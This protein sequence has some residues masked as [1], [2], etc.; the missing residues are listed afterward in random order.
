MKRSYYLLGL[1]PCVLLYWSCSSSPSSSSTT[2]TSSTS[3]TG[4]TGGG[5]GAGGGS[6]FVCPESGVTKGP[7]AL[8]AD[9]TSVKIRWEACRKGSAPEVR[10]T[11]EAGGAETVAN[12]VET[13]F[14][15]TET[16]VAP[17]IADT[18][19]DAAGTYYMHEAKLQNLSPGTCYTYSLAAEPAR[20]GRFCTMRQPGEA[21]RFMAIGDTNPGLGD[22]AENVL[23]HALP[24]NPD[25]I[26][27]G[28]DIQYYDSG[29]ETWA[30]WFPAMQPMLSQGAMYT[31][32]GN[33]ESEKPDEYEQYTV[34]FFGDASVKTAY[35]R[36]SSGGVW[37]FA[38]D[39]E[40]SLDVGS[41]Q[42]T[43]FES[44]LKDASQQPGY[45]FSVVFFHKPWVTCGDTGDNPTARAAFE[46]LL[47]QYGVKLVLQAHMHGYERFELGDLTYVTAAGG[48]GKIGDVNDNDTRDYCVNR[49]K[50][51]PFRHA[52][53]VDIKQGELMGTVI[54]DQGKVQDT[55]TKVVP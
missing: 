53:I 21:L 20:K 36:F 18:P 14:V 52:L 11:P 3:S 2:G 19:P 28:G 49:V 48:G 45:R 10:F 25:F 55:F 32:I 42:A 26:L 29:L 34:R 15:V 7:W 39:T 23:A 47:L 9:T 35:Y 41:D 33:H 54:D 24:K 13:E 1:I 31:A 6:A 17:L 43:W 46:P 51:G 30:S 27:H 5:G 4:G 38:L 40:D 12:S 22:Y 37:F 8:A 44:Q 16:Y 50:S